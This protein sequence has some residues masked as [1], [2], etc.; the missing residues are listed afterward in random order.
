MF[1]SLIVIILL[2]IVFSGFVTSIF[3][4]FNFYVYLLTCPAQHK[5]KYISPE[6]NE[7]SWNV[8]VSPSFCT[9]SPVHF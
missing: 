1:V 3:M 5:S 4:A 7:I 8:D 2:L 6:T 9:H